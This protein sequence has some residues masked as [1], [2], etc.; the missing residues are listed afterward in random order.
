MSLYTK[1]TNYNNDAKISNNELEVINKFLDF[2]RNQAFIIADKYR[3][4]FSMIPLENQKVIFKIT[5]DTLKIINFCRRIYHKGIPYVIELSLWRTSPHIET[6]PKCLV[7]HEFNIISKATKHFI[8]LDINNPQMSQILFNIISIFD[9]KKIISPEQAYSKRMYTNK[10]LQD[11]IKNHKWQNISDGIDQMPKLANALFIIDEGYESFSK[12]SANFGTILYQLIEFKKDN[13][14]KLSKT[15]LK[16][17]NKLI[18]KLSNTEL[19]KVKLLETH[20]ICK[21]M[22]T[23]SILLDTNISHNRLHLSSLYNV[24]NTRLSKERKILNK[25]IREAKNDVS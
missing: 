14:S 15:D 3:Q 16:N 7:I 17:L 1:Y 18:L 11:F 10:V 20:G 24:Y 8:S 13:L 23:N 22:P 2:Y 12:Y 6:D 25:S 21:C 9:E 19:L 5:E 4:D